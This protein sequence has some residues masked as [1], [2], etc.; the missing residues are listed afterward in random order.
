MR[1]LGLLSLIRRDFALI[2]GKFW[3]MPENLSDSSSLP[4][5]SSPKSLELIIFVGLQASG[6]STFYRTHFT[7]S[8]E[9]ISK[10]LMRNNKN[11]ERRQQQLLTEMLEAGRSV[12]V[13]N[14][15]PTAADRVRLIAIAQRF[16]ARITGYWFESEVRACRDRNLQRKGKARVPDVGLYATAKKLV[17]PTATEGFHQLYGVRIIGD[18]KFEVQPKG[19]ENKSEAREVSDGS[20]SF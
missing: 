16:D 12:V 17:Q 5:S 3:T 18:G 20:E 1:S 2:C 15:N 14:T 7:E 10:D 19:E 11:R 13:D 8:H 4:K 6:K 9:L